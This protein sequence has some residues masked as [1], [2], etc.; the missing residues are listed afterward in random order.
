M[1]V[2]EFLSNFIDDNPG[3]IFTVDGKKSRRAQRASSLYPWSKKGIGVASNTD[4]ENYVVTGKDQH[5]NRLIVASKMRTNRPSGQ[6][7][8][9]FLICPFCQILIYR[10]LHLLGKADIEM[11]LRQ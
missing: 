9:R 4:H 5:S 6:G 2:P 1:K 10:P 11:N 8:M 7:L 3:E